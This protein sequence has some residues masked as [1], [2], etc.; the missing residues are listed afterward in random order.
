MR[1]AFP[2]FGLIG[3]GFGGERREGEKRRV[4]SPVG[5]GLLARAIKKFL[6]KRD[7]IRL[8]MLGVP[9][10]RSDDGGPRMVRKGTGCR[11]EA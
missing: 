11:V 2:G 7:N 9:E 4:V 8:R 10:E 6:P 1:S 5:L 3:F